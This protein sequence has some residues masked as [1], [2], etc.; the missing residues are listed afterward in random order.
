[1]PVSSTVFVRCSWVMIK[2]THTRAHK[3]SHTHTQAHIFTKRTTSPGQVGRGLRIGLQGSVV[4]VGHGPCK[5]MVVYSR[6]HGMQRCKRRCILKY[7]VTP[8]ILE[9]KQ[10]PLPPSPQ[11]FSV[12]RS[13]SPGEALVPPP[14]HLHHLLLLHASKA[15]LIL[16]NGFL[17]VFWRIFISKN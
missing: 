1:M 3:V 11:S 4:K 9:Y 15:F 10:H 2:G 6:V 17:N 8:S 14:P 12:M 13:L 5:G 16:I 7:Q